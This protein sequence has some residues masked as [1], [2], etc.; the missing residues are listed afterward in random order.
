MLTAI[1]SAT[2]GAQLG[3]YNPPPG[4]Q[5]TFA[6]KNAHIFPVSGPEI[7]NGTVVISGGKIQA[8]GAN[9]TIPAGAQ[10]I[11][12]T[13]LNVYPGM[14]DAGTS[15]GLS[16][17]PQGAASTVDISEIGSFNPNAQAIYGINPHSAH[18]GVARVVG[19]TRTSSRVP[20]AASS[21]GKRQ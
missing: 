2:A 8:I 5:G 6:I 20:R 21:P 18:V 10:V 15:I 4:P 19:I 12:G 13:G 3:S 7:N 14:M 9:A 17:I 11:D 16:E 1:A